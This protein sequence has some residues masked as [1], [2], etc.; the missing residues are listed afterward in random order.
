MQCIVD[1]LKLHAT[2]EHISVHLDIIG[3]DNLNSTM[4]VNYRYAGT[5][6]YLL[7][8]DTMLLIFYTK[9]IWTDINTQPTDSSILLA[10]GVSLSNIELPSV[11]DGAIDR[12]GVEVGMAIPTLRHDFQ[13]DVQH[14]YYYDL[15][16]K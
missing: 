12:R 10:G 3:D 5:L 4:D 2:F 16:W 1:S 14:K 13:W 11:E 6:S 7:A 15:E 9:I 8:A